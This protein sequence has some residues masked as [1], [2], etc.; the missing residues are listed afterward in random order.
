MRVWGKSI[1]H[2]LNANFMTGSLTDNSSLCMPF[3]EQQKLLHEEM[4]P[5]MPVLYRYAMKLTLDKDAAGDL[6]QETYLKACRYL[7]HFRHGS[8]A[9]AWLYRIL[10]NTF[11]NDYRRAKRAPTQNGLEDLLVKG[12]IPVSSLTTSVTPTRWSDRS[13]SDEVSLAMRAL[14]ADYRAVVVL[15]DIEGFSYDEIAEITAVPVGTVRSRLHRGRNI[16]RK[17]LLKYAAANGYVAT[18]PELATSLA[19]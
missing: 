16:L 5:H 8:N 3:A 15:C 4:L 2:L 13:L 18:E 6:V 10:K 1:Y 14:P 9:K 7:E 12:K 17:R 11:I 19:A